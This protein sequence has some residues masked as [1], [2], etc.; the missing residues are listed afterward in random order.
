M[1]VWPVTGRAVLFTVRFMGLMK[2][3]VDES[4][5][6]YIWRGHLEVFAPECGVVRGFAATSFSLSD[7]G[8]FDKVSVYLNSFDSNGNR[9]W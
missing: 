8:F 4:D 2:L 3:L 6:I 5:V 9:K 7:P 1:R